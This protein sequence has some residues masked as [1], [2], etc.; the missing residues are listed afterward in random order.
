MPYSLDQIKQFTSLDLES[1]EIRGAKTGV[2]N[3]RSTGPLYDT[4]LY[5][6]LKSILSGSVTTLFGDSTV[7]GISIVGGY[8]AQNLVAGDTIIAGSATLAV[9]NIVDATSATVYPTPNVSTT[10]TDATYSLVARHYL[11][12]PDVESNTA[13]GY[14]T[15]T[16]G[17]TSITGTGFLDTSAGDAIQLNTLQKYFIIHHVVN[18]TSCE[19]TSPFT[20]L[21]DSGIFTAKR[22]RLGRLTYQHTKNE[23]DYNTQTGRW[24]YD[25][26]TGGD[27]TA[28]SVFSSFRDGIDLKFSQTLKPSKYPDLMDS[29]LVLGKVLSR[30]TTYDMFQYPLPAVPN[31]EE[32]FD[33]F[34]NGTKKVNGKDYVLN[35]SQMPVYQYPPPMD[36]RQVANVM[37]MKYIQDSTLSPAATATGVLTFTDASGNVLQGIMPGTETIKVDGTVQIPNEDYV[38]DL[39]SGV[40]YDSTVITDEPVVSY[41]MYQKEG[42]YDLGLNITK[43]GTAQKL[44]IPASNSDDVIFDLE[45][46]RLKPATQDN[47]GPG[48]EYIVSYYKEG[49]Y[50]SD[51]IIPVSSYDFSV[52]V[53]NYPIKPQ[54][55]ILAKNGAY[56]DENVDF[57]V[58]CLTGRIVFF[59]S[60]NPGDSIVVSYSPLIKQVNGLTYDG[61]LNYTQVY[62][63][64]TT[65]HSTTPL[66]FVFTNPDL[67]ILDTPPTVT[68]VYNVTRGDATYD[69]NGC[70]FSGTNLELVSNAYNTSIGTQLSD[71]VA[72]SYKFQND[73]VEFTPV[74]T[75]NFMMPQDANFIALVN[76]FVPGDF[77]MGYMMRMTNVDTAGDFYFRILYSS[78]DGEDTIVGFEGRAPSDIIN[79][80]IFIS[81]GVGSLLPVTS[82]AYPVMKGATEVQFPG[83]VAV[84]ELRP[85]QL[86]NIGTDYYSI[87][88][89]AYDSSR[90]RSIVTFNVESFQD[91]TSTTTLSSVNYT[92]Y[93][94][95]YEGDT[96]VSTR[97]GIITEPPAPVMSL[98]YNGYATVTKDSSAFSVDIGNT[99]YTLLDTSYST[100]ADISSALSGIPG[101][102]VNLYTSSWYTPKLNTFSNLVVTQD[103]STLVTGMEA[104]RLWGNDTTEFSTAGGV[105]TL[106]NPLIA[107][108]RYNFDYLGQKSLGDSTVVFSGS[109]FTYLPAKSQVA[110][111]MKYDNLDQF[112]IQVLSQRQFLEN[113]IQPEKTEEAIQQSGNVG[114]GGDIQGDEAGAKE[115]GGL[116]NDEFR[117]ADASITCNVFDNIFDFFNLRLQSYADEVYALKGWKLCNN[118]GLLSEEDQSNGASSINRMFPWSDYTSMP[119]YPI[120]C[121]TGQAVPYAIAGPKK[122]TTKKNSPCRA[123]FSGSDVTCTTQSTPSYWTKQLRVGDLIR[124]IDRSVNHTITSIISDTRLTINPPYSGAT[125]KPFVMTSKF[126]LYD[127]DGYTGP[128]IIGTNYEDFGLKDGDM[129]DIQVDGSDQ[130]YVFQDPTNPLLAALFPLSGLTATDVARIISAAL[131]IKVSVEWI[132]DQ[133]SAYGYSTGLVARV[134]G[135]RNNLITKHGAAVAKL[136]FPL[137]STVYGNNDNTHANP[138]FVYLSAERA[139]R[140]TQL[141]ALSNSLGIANKLARPNSDAITVRNMALDESTQINN[142]MQLLNRELAALQVLLDEPSMPGYANSVVADASARQFMS[143][144]SVALI[145]DQSIFT[146]YQGFV[147]AQKWIVNL[148]HRDSTVV[149]GKRLGFAWP[150]YSGTGVT[151]IL[152]QTTFAVGIE[153]NYD[154][155]I[156]DGSVDGTYFPAAVYYQDTS[157]PVEGSWTGFASG[158]SVDQT[159]TYYLNS[160]PL[161]TLKPYPETFTV[162]VTALSAVAVGWSRGITYFDFLT[163]PTVGDLKTAIS[164]VPGLLASGPGAY[165]SLPSTDLTTMATTFLSPS[166]GLADNSSVVLMTVTYDGIYNFAYNVDTS[167][168]GINWDSSGVYLPYTSYDYPYGVLA[169]KYSINTTIPGLDATGDSIHDSSNPKGIVITGSTAIPPDATL[170]SGLRECFLDLWT[171]DDKNLRDR[172]SYDNTRIMQL[173]SRLRYLDVRESQIKSDFL[174][175]EFLMS[176]DT[177]STGNIYDWADNRFNRSAGCE[178][179][180]KQIEKQIQVSQS[181]LQISRRF[182]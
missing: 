21:T 75:I 24:V 114:Q 137:D 174:Q 121:L 106:T 39:N 126:P 87:I 102:S 100:S 133:D 98:N 43:D 115:Q 31:P 103:S 132:Y 109:Y 162:D 110:V 67:L 82:T 140:V 19:L 54:S 65:V 17:S 149:H 97:Y 144:S 166:V 146:D 96:V 173:D 92:D 148:Q 111:S 116:V 156:L 66:S 4:G 177:S 3:A 16:Q 128:K 55:V 169:M 141:G 14:A 44:T 181:G 37:F 29:N 145:Y 91:Y 8:N 154:R 119:P 83:N 138:E 89:S 179:R 131:D 60:L 127:D 143:D 88:S 40:G 170:Y 163:Y 46:G 152:G 175:E 50:V 64:E 118:D 26:T 11:I 123:I 13:T 113:V 117:R 157:S 70:K 178:A 25:S 36:Q 158:Y 2:N 176:S 112:Y 136:G 76:Q 56:L 35:Y 15:F 147:A 95:Y 168:L 28:Y 79:P 142:E 53:K 30:S 125:Y 12:E 105:L 161:F 122:P 80:A 160:Q 10:V 172:S 58:S 129:F 38:I 1:F 63:S 81:D 51:E 159:V 180:L 85:G 41:V 124:P 48:E 135:T 120:T 68:G 5:S 20:G 7:R 32:S 153:D 78:Y 23:F 73:G 86:L 93:P 6:P 165:D 155:R 47:P 107:G 77:P 164:L 59:T 182:L 167:G 101:F 108:Q 71:V 151:N 84:G 134:D 52:R 94:F 45:S 42:L 27:Q 22:W 9:T 62:K 33:L 69:I 34:I 130:S 74:Q 61:G 49:E 57:R 99:H 18:D 90:G 104:L 150:N 171:I 139:D 72:L